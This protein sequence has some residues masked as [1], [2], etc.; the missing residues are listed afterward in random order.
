MERPDVKKND[1]ILLKNA[2]DDEGI[3]ALVFKVEEDGTLFVGYHAYSIKT[4]KAC[5]FWTGTYWKVMDR[6]SQPRP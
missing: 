1:Y 3:E 5:A 4:L 2:E 6:K